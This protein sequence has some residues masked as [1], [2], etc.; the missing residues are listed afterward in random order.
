MLFWMPG[1]LEYLVWCGYGA[2][3]FSHA[4]HVLGVNNQIHEADALSHSLILLGSPQNFWRLWH[5]Y[6][7]AA[8][9]FL[10]DPR[11]CSVYSLLV[12]F[13]PSKVYF[14]LPSAGEVTSFRVPLL[15]RWMDTAFSSLFLL[16]PF[17]ILLSRCNYLGLKLSTLIKGSL[18][19]FWTAF[20]LSQQVVHD[21]KSCH[22]SSSSNR[23]PI[24]NDLMLVVWHSFYLHLLDHCMFGQLVP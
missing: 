4:Q 11:P 1:P 15:S 14:L 17:S 24:T 7:R 13:S 2:A 19:R 20:S 10:L 8:M 16:G 6:L 12:W 5:H 23:L 3:S 9:L 21:T 18:I 22:D